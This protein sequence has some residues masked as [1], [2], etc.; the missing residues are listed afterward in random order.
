MR[1]HTSVGPLLPLPARH[2]LPSPFQGQSCSGSV[3]RSIGA[4]G[5]AGV[6]PLVTRYRALILNAVEHGLS[7]ACFEATNIHLRLLIGR[8]YGYHSPDALI[9]SPTSPVAVS[10]HHSPDDHDNPPTECQ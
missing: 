1:S 3:L 10:A 8:S 7:N 4:Q 6:E 9:A 2:A 5:L